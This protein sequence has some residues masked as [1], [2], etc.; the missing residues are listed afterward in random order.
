MADVSLNSYL[1]DLILAVEEEME[2]V[3]SHRRVFTLGRATRVPTASNRPLYFFPVA[4]PPRFQDEVRGRL[5]VGEVEIDCVAINRRDDGI[6]VATFTDLGEEIHSATLTVDRSDILAVLAARLVAIRDGTAALPFNTSLVE[7]AINAAS[8]ARE[9]SPAFIATPDDLTDDQKEAFRRVFRNEVSYLWGPPGTGKTTTLSAIAT[10]MFRDHKRILLVSHTNQAVD[11]VLRALC[12]RIVG[13]SRRALPEGSVVRLGAISRRNLEGEFGEQIGVEAV[14]EAYQRKLAT[15]REGAA[16]EVEANRKELEET[17]ELLALATSQALLTE[18]LHSLTNMLA[19]ARSSEGSLRAI[20]RVLRVKYPSSAK[21]GESVDDIKASIRTVQS[22]LFDAATRLNGE[23]VTSLEHRAKDLE[24]RDTELQEAL[25]DLESLGRDAF[26]GVIHRARVVACTATQALLRVNALKDF[27]VVVVDEASMIPLPLAIFLSG[28][29]RERLVLGGDFRQLPPVSLS[30]KDLVK[31]SYARDIFEASG[32]V[33]LVESGEGR[34]AIAILSTQFRGTQEL[35]S[36]INGRFYG[37]RLTSKG[38]SHSL[39]DGGERPTLLPPGSVGIVDTSML[40]A[41]GFR[42]ERSKGN[43]IHAV[44]TREACRL[45]KSAG[46]VKST[47]DLGVIAPYRPQVAVI[48]ELLKEA[49]ISPVSVGTVHRFQG[50]EREF[51]ILDL[52]ESEPHSL[53]SF[54]S[55]RSP[56]DIGARLLNVALSRANAYLLIIA[57]LQYLNQRLNEDHILYGILRDAAECGGVMNAERLLTQATEISEKGSI[58]TG[59]VVSP[60]QFFSGES[61]LSA[62]TTD[63]R[64]AQRSALVISKSLS[65]R[66]VRALAS[67][68]GSL[69]ARGVACEAIVPRDL[70]SSSPEGLAWLELLTSVGVAVTPHDA[71]STSGVVL[72]DEVVWCGATDP[73]QVVDASSPCLL[74]VVSSVL[75]EALRSSQGWQHGE[76][77]PG[78]VVNL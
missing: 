37:G 74:R 48:D 9:G 66:S 2:E 57:N 22:R 68:L 70:T 25:T 60:P 64:G 73:L 65:E 47:G 11:G 62:L 15:L 14:C 49:G 53:G 52:T 41:T 63:L 29:G 8:G 39:T 54:L 42:S 75:A 43:L 38:S 26:S 50:A 36:L 23:D 27:D 6:D 17:R 7:K 77:Q 18:E 19:K 13:K 55:A 5:T 10:Q 58:P 4:N 21:E 72:D 76:T 33:A 78:R 51:I 61:V 45:F 12:Q 32:M 40:G 69:A 28:L 44:V 67:E 20:L 56:R 30:T 24:A 31:N 34:D 1:S 46:L 71:I 35:S 16:K 59:S 3:R